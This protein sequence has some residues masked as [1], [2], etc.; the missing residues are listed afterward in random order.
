M[1]D[2]SDERPRRWW[3][4]YRTVWRWHFYAGLFCIPFVIVLSISGT[5]YLFKE[6]IE[7]QIERPYDQISSDG[8]VQ[9]IAQQVEAALASVPDS[10]P[11]G[12]ELRRTETSAARVLVRDAEGESIRVYVDPKSLKV[13]GSVNDRE[14]L[15]RQMFRLHGELWMGDRGS[16][17]VELAASWTIVMVLTGLYLWWPSGPNWMAGAIYPRLFS[18][19]KIWW[20][21][22]HSV[23]GVWISFLT[24]FLLASGLPWAKFWGS[25]LKQVR[26]V[27]G[28]AVAQQ[29][30]TTGS[31]RASGRARGQGAGEDHSGHGGSKSGK[32][33]KRSLSKDE[34]TAFDRIA[35][36]VVPLK[37]A[38]P[39]TIAPPSRGGEWTAKSTTPNRPYRVNLVVDG[40]SGEI[41]SRE[42]FN[43]R[44]IIDQI[45]GYGIAAHEGRLFGWPNQLLGL[46]TA[47]GLVLLSVSGI[48]MWW[49]RRNPGT[50]GTPPPSRSPYAL[51][52]IL[53]I[54]LA[55]AVYLPLFGMSFLVVV[56]LEYVV[57]RR[58]PAV[59][60][61]LGLQQ[62]ND[63]TQPT[64]VAL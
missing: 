45:V 57:L 10:A 6:E 4:D 51:I 52:P 25:Y 21:D 42:N 49:R 37:L 41:V 7:A 29:D 30:W 24:L 62:P 34:L 3:P 27:T 11:S 39:V 48:V 19:S 61:W 2:N 15:M 14:R 60:D 63:A 43:D 64:G 53:L 46:V 44:H 32:P 16:N 47:V 35:A 20:R 18:G 9:P 26:S 28:T 22:V 31:D 17:V 59:R 58:I 36:T 12:Y 55:L 5:V 56:V 13:L 33:Q 23:T 54:V 38:H 1:S 40:A 50:L 8:E